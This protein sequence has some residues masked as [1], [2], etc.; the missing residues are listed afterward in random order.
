M[1]NCYT[2]RSLESGL[3][4][5]FRANFV[6]GNYD[7]LNRR[8]TSFDLYIGVNLWTVV[9]MSR[10]G[11]DLGDTATVE[12]IVVVPHNL[13]QVCL[14]NTGGGTPFISGL[15][16][17]ALKMSLYP[18]A[19]AA[20]G[21]VKRYRNNLAA[22]NGSTIRYPDDPYDRIWDPWSRPTTWAEMSTTKRVESFDGDFFEAP[23]L[24]LQTAVTPLNAS[25]NIKFGW[26][27]EPEPKNPWPGYIAIMYFAELQLLDGNA[28]RQFYIN[29][30]GEPETVVEPDYLS[31]VNIYNP[32]PN[33]RQS[34]YDFSLNATANSTL[35][36]I[37]NALEV[38][39]LIPTTNLGTDFQDASAAMEIK[40][41]YKVEKNWMG[42]PC[43]PQTMTW[44]RLNCSH[45]NPPRITSINLSSS[46]LKGDMSSSFAN[47]KGLEYL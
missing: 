42:D 4:Y 18:Q 17:R 44:D 37:M 16:V 27:A 22:I 38:F 12:A 47:L 28:S 23:M 41:K 14:V 21:L 40:A 24:V 10:W 30:D 46:G 20:G 5:L 26:D 19:T 33:K 31:R 34:S 7:G 45:A 36:P 39:S 32:F 9:N 25:E 15:D 13:V 2:L 11:S 35:P 29:L 8:P 1:R 3:K 43:L 6:Y